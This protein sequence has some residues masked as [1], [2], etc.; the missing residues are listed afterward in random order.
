MGSV[1]RMPKKPGTPSQPAAPLPHR[2]SSTSRLVVALVA[3]LFA[4]GLFAYIRAGQAQ[5]GQAPEAAVAPG[6]PGGS[7]SSPPD[8][9]AAGP[10]AYPRVGPHKQPAPP[11]P[12]AS[13]YPPARPPAVVP[14]DF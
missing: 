2:R 7:S 1:T 10:P 9:Q 8:V 5:T 13:P 12:P 14:V 3:V 4:I 6:T 11:P